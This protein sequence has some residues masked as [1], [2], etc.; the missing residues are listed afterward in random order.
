MKHILLFG[1]GK[2]STVL[3]EYLKNITQKKGW[4]ATV[5][6]ADF[7]VAKAKTGGAKELLPIGL[8]IEDEPKR[9]ALIHEADIVISMMPPALHYLIAKDCLSIGKQLLTASYVSNEIKQLQ[10]E[11]ERKGLLFL[12]EMGLDP[13]I[14]H[15]SAMEMIDDIH[16]K[17]GKITAFKSHCGGLVAPESD[18]NPWHYKISWNPRNVVL[19]GKQGATFKEDGVVQQVDYDHIFKY[20]PAIV[21]PGVGNL[22]YYPNRDSLSYLETYQLAGTHTFVRTTLRYEDYCTGWSFIVDCK[23][24]DEEKVYD[25]QKLTYRSFFKNHLERFDLQEVVRL[26]LSKNTD[27]QEQLKYLG[28]F[29]DTL[30]NK[31]LCS[32]ADILQ[33]CL[34]TNLALDPKDKDMIVMMH[35]IEYELNGRKHAIESSLLVKGEDSL[36]TAMAKTVGL[37]LGIAATLILE[38]KITLKGLHIPILPEIYK[39]VLKALEEYDVKFETRMV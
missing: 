29:D 38:G 31:G 24:T 2:S 4:K 8:N 10:A 5:A 33:I 34:E 37:P 35:E 9:Q 13:G 19:A 17:G 39:P 28:L 7:E 15:M 3:I 18:N 1:A 6:D 16:S 12:C 25:T 21:F 30:I 20:C 11:I 22:A 36:H 27:L 23:L 26:V 32:A 14:D